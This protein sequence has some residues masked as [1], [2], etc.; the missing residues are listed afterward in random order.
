MQLL[1]I[2]FSDIFTSILMCFCGLMKQ[3]CCPTRQSLKENTYLSLAIIV[4]VVWCY[5]FLNVN[6]EWCYKFLFLLCH[7]DI[8]NTF[9]GCDTT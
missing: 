3:G 5:N 4:E 7:L 8:E 1:S 6:M 2:N 9:C